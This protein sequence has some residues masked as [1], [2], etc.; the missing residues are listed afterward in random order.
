[1]VVCSNLTYGGVV[2]V[3]DSNLLHLLLAYSASHR[4]RLLN[5]R[6]PTNRIARWVRDVFP[7]LRRAL[8][9]PTGQV[10]NTNLATAI[11][12]ASLQIISP[13]TFEVE[14][15]WQNHLRTARSMLL[16]RR[17]AGSVH[18]KDRVSYFLSR[19]FAYLD[20][21]GSLSG[22]K[23][24]QPVFIGDYWVDDDVD[25][26]GY[27][28][29]IDC[30]LGFT[31]RCIS[32]L[33]QVAELARICD[34]ERINAE[35]VILDNWRPPNARIAQAE[36]LKLDLQESRTR[37]YPGCCPH[38]HDGEE[39][40]ESW[41]SVEMEATNDAFHWAGLVH[42]NRRVLGKNSQDREVQT[43]VKEIVNALDRVRKGSTAEACLLFP[44]FTAGCDAL[45][46]DQRNNIMGRLKVVEG[47]G[48]THVSF[49]SLYILPLN[50][51]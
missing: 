13:N 14:V 24:D 20:V 51:N 28:F 44:M 12:L 33:A 10:S 7:S 37:R 29:Q 26:G 27:S 11:M 19:W 23:N 32:I 2:A 15:S 16:A 21:L 1:M 18:R 31:S 6:E 48:M 50:R 22:G 49:D 45:E 39:D 41:D 30:L 42:L 47:T 9:D 38:H 40:E 35:G 17:G 3:G 46:G 43:A 25:E 5:H 36:Q 4:A 8:D 34:S